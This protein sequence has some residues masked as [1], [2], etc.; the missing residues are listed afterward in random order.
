MALGK[1]FAVSGLRSPS[2]LWE[3]CTLGGVLTLS[4]PMTLFSLPFGSLSLGHTLSS[5]LELGLCPS[6]LAHWP[7]LG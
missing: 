1:P 3:W 5:S 2:V 7:W 4:D 6:L